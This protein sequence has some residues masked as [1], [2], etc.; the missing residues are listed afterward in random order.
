MSKLNLVNRTELSLIYGKNV[1]TID[2]WIR[3]GLPYE[4][5][6]SKGTGWLFDTTKVIAWRERQ[7]REEASST[8]RI[9]LD[10]A[11]RRKVAAE[12]GIL[13]IELQQKRREV[14]STDEVT[15]GLAHAYL[16]VKQRLRTIPERVVPQLIAEDDEQICREILLN[17]IDD[18]LLEL[19]QMD[20]DASP[21]E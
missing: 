4:E 20:F 17:E 15:Q 16:T 8:E 13:E 1:S 5:K 9:E 6:G 10:E 18:A 12:A 7:L 21:A 19:S 3:Q 14:I 11:K 2:T